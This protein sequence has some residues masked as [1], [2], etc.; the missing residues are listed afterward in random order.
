MNQARQVFYDGVAYAEKHFGEK[1]RVSAPG[2][3]TDRGRIYVKY[4]EP[5]EQLDRFRP[6]ARYLTRSGATGGAVTAT[7]CLPTAPTG[8]V[9]ISWCIRTT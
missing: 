3:R 7:T 5:E 4:G 6:A 2:W 8:S 9:S 1:G